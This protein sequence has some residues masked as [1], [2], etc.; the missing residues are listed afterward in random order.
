M[1]DAQDR[2]KPFQPPSNIVIVAIERV[3][4]RARIYSQGGAIH[5]FVAIAGEVE[6]MLAGKGK[7]HASAKTL[8]NGEVKI[9]ARVVDRTW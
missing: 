7:V 9:L 1:V 6:A 5:D 4:K 2:N 8:K 3:G